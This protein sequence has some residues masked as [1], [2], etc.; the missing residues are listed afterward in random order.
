MILF[1]P[2]N[3]ARA[4]VLAGWQGDGHSRAAGIFTTLWYGLLW[5]LLSLSVVGSGP[6]FLSAWRS[7]HE[8]VR[9]R[10]VFGRRSESQ[11]VIPK[12]WDEDLRHS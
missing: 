2:F 3:W 12:L 1:R 11:E 8:I 7:V 10:K 4:I 6:V 9:N 5:P